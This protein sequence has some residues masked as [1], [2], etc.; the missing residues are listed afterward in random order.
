VLEFVFDKIRS[1]A[2]PR[3]WY[4]F[5]QHVLR[6]RPGAELAQEL[7]ITANAVCVNAGRILDRVCTMCADY[8]EELDE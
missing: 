6:G 7:G 5:E 1:Q 4:C 2:Q 3:T 8:M